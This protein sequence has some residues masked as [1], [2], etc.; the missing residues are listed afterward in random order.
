MLIL[1][2][3]CIHD[4]GLTSCAAPLTLLLERR[5][6]GASASLASF[7]PQASLRTLS[8][9]PLTALVL[10]FCMLAQRHLIQLMGSAQFESLP[11]RFD[12]RLS[13]A[14]IQRLPLRTF[15]LRADG[16]RDWQYPCTVRRAL[17]A[18]QVPRPSCS[19]SPAATCGRRTRRGGRERT[20]G[21]VGED[22]PLPIPTRRS[23]M[24]CLRSNYMVSRIMKPGVAGHL[25][26]GGWSCQTLPST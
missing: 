9:P 5:H 23:C 12:T 24:A 19:S 17:F 15:A 1:R 11:T 25:S 13:A 8:S 3:L 16:T 21:R 14:K 22:L 4:D 20:T 7:H 18:A 26:N 6:C 2:S 10:S